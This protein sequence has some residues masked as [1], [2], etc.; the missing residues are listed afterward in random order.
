MD[1][2]GELMVRS[3]KKSNIAHA[4]Q[5][6]G[7]CTLLNRT[8]PSQNLLYRNQLNQETAK[9]Y[10]AKSYSAKPESDK[11]RIWNLLNHTWP[12]RNLLNPKSAK[13]YSA[14]PESAKPCYGSPA[15]A[16]GQPKLKH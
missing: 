13:P 10:L 15:E 12:N 14:K 2:L 4:E 11:T 9:P 8:L 6:R 5:S 3:R 7:M 16:L 1:P